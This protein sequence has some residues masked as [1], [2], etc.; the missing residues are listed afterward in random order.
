MSQRTRR[1]IRFLVFILV[2]MA[3]IWGGYK[4]NREI[5]IDSCLDR[6][7]S[8]HHDMGECSYTESYLGPDN[9]DIP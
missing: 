1:T 7:G 5:A 2:I 8:W 9:L 4:I 3:T 6:G